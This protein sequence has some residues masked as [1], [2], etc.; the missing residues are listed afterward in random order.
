MFALP[1]L[2]IVSLLLVSA[3]LISHAMAGYNPDISN[4][5]CYYGSGNQAPSR[6]IPCGNSALGHKTCCESQDMCLSS[7]ACYNAQ[8]GVTYLAGCT[9]P[10]YENEACP[11]KGAYADQTWAGLVYCNGTSNQWMAC[12]ELGGTTVSKPT[13]SLCWCPETSRTVAFEDASVLDNIMALPIVTGLSVT[14][15]D[16]ASYS[17]EHA[18]TSAADPTTS[19]ATSASSGSVSKTSVSSTSASP[20]VFTQILTTGSS[21]TTA[22]PTT[23]SSSPTPTGDPEAAKT[24]AE[25]GIALGAACGAIIL[26]LLTLLALRYMRRRQKRKQDEQHKLPMM[27]LTRPHSDAQIDPDMR[28]PAWSGHKSELAADE[29]TRI[30]PAPRYQELNNKNR[31]QNVEFETSSARPPPVQPTR[32]GGYTMPGRNGT[33]YEMGD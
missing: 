9:D 2:L 29:T 24:R 22:S 16:S 17:S 13:P 30:S 21:S 27:D 28:S 7:R 25:I 8:Y 10:D 1:R 5:T 32:D 4:G 3:N 31:P 18:L 15:E 14:W 33:Y 12:E 19:S 6:F 23:S 26:L 20:T 11:D